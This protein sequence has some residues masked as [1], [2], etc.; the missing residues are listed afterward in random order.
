MGNGFGSLM[1]KWHLL[2]SLILLSLTCTMDGAAMNPP[3]LEL[4]VSDEGKEL[5]EILDKLLRTESALSRADASNPF[6]EREIQTDKKLIE[7]LLRSKGYYGAQIK[8]VLTRDGSKGANI[9]FQIISGPLYHISEITIQ[10]EASWLNSPET[11]S[12]QLQTGDPLD[13]NA[14]LKALTEIF[15]KAKRSTGLIT[16]ERGHKVSLDHRNAL[17]AVTYRLFGQKRGVFSETEF[18]GLSSVQEAHLRD[19]IPWETG[20]PFSVEKVDTLR[21]LYI[22]TGLF[23]FVDT[24]PL[25]SDNDQGPVRIKVLL[26][27]RLH[28]SLELGFW[29][30]SDENIG[31]R[32]GWEH[33]NIGGKGRKLALSSEFS[34]CGRI[35]KVDVHYLPLLYGEGQL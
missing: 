21:Q 27:E 17:G 6:L 2:Y 9:D 20:D 29:A 24:L 12:L 5:T 3:R 16:L 13:A 18:E 25:P 7:K 33:R 19:M 22:A 11:G 4:R 23:S 26:R 8:A 35:W 14:I 31:L 10:K 28:R 30:T 1:V 32:A 34:L 15:E